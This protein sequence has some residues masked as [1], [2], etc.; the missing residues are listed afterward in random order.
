MEVIIVQV[1]PSTWCQ[2]AKESQR[3]QC[4]RNGLG[5]GRQRGGGRKLEPEGGLGEVRELETGGE[6]ILTSKENGSPALHF[7][8]IENT[9]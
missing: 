4:Q 6:S 1:L 3:L 9:R 5:R 7:A 8:V 2:K